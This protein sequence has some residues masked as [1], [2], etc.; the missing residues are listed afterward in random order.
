MSKKYSNEELMAALDELDSKQNVSGVI[1][2]S[3]FG[4]IPAGI[5][6]YVFALMGGIV[7]WFIFI[8]SAI[9][10]LQAAYLGRAYQ[11]KYRLIPAFVALV[12]HLG[13]T[14]IIFNFHPVMLL[15][16]PLSFGMAM[17]TGKRKLEYVH[18]TALFERERG[19]IS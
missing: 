3:L 11:F 10:G 7:A 9:V 18:H 6:F 5:I 15:T 12:L 16:A 13:V 2:G 1:I 4:V 19:K 17:I 8:P 14:A